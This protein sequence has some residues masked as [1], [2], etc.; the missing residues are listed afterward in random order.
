MLELV[1]DPLFPPTDYTP[2]ENKNFE[3]LHKEISF[4]RINPLRSGSTD[5]KRKN[6]YPLTDHSTSN[7]SHHKDYQKNSV[8]KRRNS[9]SIGLASFQSTEKH[10]KIRYS[11][12]V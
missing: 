5:A 10:M 3:L 6:Y 8:N 12:P 9:E 2:L 4:Y 7:S 1:L 11:T